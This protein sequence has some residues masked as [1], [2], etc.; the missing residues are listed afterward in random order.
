MVEMI[1]NG[2]LDFHNLGIISL[3][4]V[5]QRMVIYTVN[6]INSVCEDGIKI[7]GMK[8]KTSEKLKQKLF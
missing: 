5:G 3:L 6:T 4:M 7:I 2:Q 8:I 1:S